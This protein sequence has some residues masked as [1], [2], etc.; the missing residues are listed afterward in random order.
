MT[1]GSYFRKREQINSL[2]SEIDRRL[3]V[4]SST[5]LWYTYAENLAGALSISLH[6]ALSMTLAMIST[7]F[8]ED[9][10]ARCMDKPLQLVAEWEQR[11]QAQPSSEAKSGANT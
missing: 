11:C 2:V 9:D 10:F 1:N 7:G 3:P 4:T 6:E 8:G 5:V